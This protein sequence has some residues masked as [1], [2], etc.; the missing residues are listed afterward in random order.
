M[1]GIEELQVSIETEL[2]EIN[3]DKL[4]DVAEYM[5]I[6]NTDG[7]SKLF[8]IRKIREELEKNIAASESEGQGDLLAVSRY[9]KQILAFMDGELSIMETTRDENGGEMAARALAEAKED[10]AKLQNEFMIMMSLQEKKILEAKERIQKLCSQ[11]PQD[12]TPHT[13]ANVVHHP[14]PSPILSHNPSP[15]LRFPSSQPPV[16]GFPACLMS[17]TPLFFLDRCQSSSFNMQHR[18]HTQPGESVFADDRNLSVRNMLRFKD[19]KVQGTIS[20]EKS[21]ISYTNL[22]KQIESAVAKGY[23]ETEIVD[24]VINAVSPSLHLRAYLEGI[25]GLS[26]SDLRRILRSHYCEKSATEAYQE[27][28]NV[29]QESSETPQNF[30]KRALKLRQHVMLASQE[31]DSKIR[32]DENLIRNVF[33]N[34]VE[35]GFADDSICSRMRRFLQS[36]NVSD[37]TLMREINIA[38]TA[39]NERLAKLGARKRVTKPSQIAVAATEVSTGKPAAQETKKGKQDV[40][41]ASL[42]EVRADVASLKQAMT[43]T[44]AENESGLKRPTRPPSTCDACVSNDTRDKCTHCFVCGSDEHFARGCKKRKQRGNRGQLHPRDAV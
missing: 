20:S 25:K 14:A 4:R 34:A 36:P 23:L 19:F 7:K 11:V 39:E 12:P 43:T 15:N 17:P 8:I 22:N 10:Y 6:E 30:L 32:Y 24:A 29:V 33:M 37:E 44:R 21:R 2:Y 9:L 28:T 31:K 42:Q 13:Q 26:L 1:E 41:I 18:P 16:L 27:L 35:T 38:M 5:L 3:Y 40:L